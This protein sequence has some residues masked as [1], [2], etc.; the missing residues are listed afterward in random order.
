MSEDKRRFLSRWSQRKLDAAKAASQPKPVPPPIAVAKP[1][2]KPELPSI[3]TL[4]GLASEYKDFLRPGVDEKLRQA[5]LKKL[6]H[7]PHF[8][9]MDGL[10]VYID[11]Y[12]KPDPIPDA[13]LRGLAHARGLLFA[14]E[15]EEPKQAADQPAATALPEAPMAS[16]PEPMTLAEKKDKV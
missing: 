15:K 8:N 14:E 3:E 4:R 13:V 11:D 5:A 16:A 1:E 7:D 10:D 6:F 2:V 9:V 12:S